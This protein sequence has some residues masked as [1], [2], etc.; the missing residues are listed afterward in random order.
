VGK[1]NNMILVPKD[2]TSTARR[3]C[4]PYHTDLSPLRGRHL[5]DGIGAVA[6]E[7]CHVG[8]HQGK[9]SNFLIAKGTVFPRRETVGAGF[10]HQHE[11]FKCGLI[12]PI[13]LAIQTHCMTQSVTVN[14]CLL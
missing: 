5:N 3:G 10:H 8:P 4:C 1:V 2:N 11:P 6:T 9:A 14:V 12:P 13:A 7:L